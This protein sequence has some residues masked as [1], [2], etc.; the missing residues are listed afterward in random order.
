MPITFDT[1]ACRNFDNAIQNEWLAT[2]GLG[3]Y[4]SGTVAGA[5]SR[6]YHGYLVVAV[7]PPVQR[8]VVLSRV[9]DSVIVGGPGDDPSAKSPGEAST[10][11]AGGGVY[12]LSTDEFSDI[13]HPQGYK[14]LISFGLTHGPTW[15]FQVGD[16]VIEKS[17]TLVHGADAVIVRYTL[18]S[19]TG[20]APV[21]LLVQPMLAG[22]DFHATIN[23]HQR[24]WWTV[25]TNPDGTL[26]MSAP[27]CP[28]KLHISHNADRFTTNA[29]WWYNFTYRLERQ[30][31]Y[32]DREDLWTPGVLEFTLTPNKPVGF[33][34]ATRPM[35]WEK[36]AELIAQ[37]QRRYDHLAA[38]FDNTDPKDD[39]L[40]CLAQAADQ[41]VVR[42]GAPESAKSHGP[43][44]AGGGG[45]GGTGGASVIAGYPWFE[46]W[47][48]DTFISLPG[49]T[50]TRGLFDVARNILATFAD[51]LRRGLLPNRFPDKSF[52]PDYNTV[53]ASLWY[54]HAAYQYWRYTGDAAFLTKYLYP[55]LCE[56]MEAYRDGTD[57]GIR[58]TDD[59]LIRAGDGNH[60]P[61][62]MDAKIGDWV[63]TPRHG[64]PVEINALWY[65]NLRIMALVAHHAGDASRATTFA[66]LADKVA[67][68]F[69]PIYFNVTT[70][71]LN[72][73][74]SDDGQADA[75]IRPNQLLAVSLPF[76]PLSTEARIGV[77][78]ACQKLLLTP[79]GL[80]TLAP[81]SPQYHGRCQGDQRNR[82]MAYHQGTVWPWLI[83]PF[84][85][86][87]VKIRGD[88]QAASREAHAF[89]LPFNDHLKHFGLG[90]ISEIADGDA[91]FTPRGCPA[92]AWSVAEVLRAYYEDVLRRAPAWPHESNTALPPRPVLV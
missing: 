37:A 78:A 41:F 59:G 30:R 1:E 67:R 56:I 45:G 55:K 54:V 69:E 2:N 18:V 20:N 38:T 74:I 81:G 10:S 64:K 9:E 22:R 83:G 70:K 82:D 28:V 88:N 16:A 89:L 60:Q 51:H 57:F 49:L 33:I 15:R 40:A 92:Q 46:D 62:W 23:L 52:T 39:F 80:R 90:S 43:S 6:K 79:M 71:C 17:L 50:L 76:S 7:K 48:R 44:G 5:N 75:S 73:V 34:A 21:K 19:R 77:V 61:T 8:F 36:S 14:N 84:V 25:D 26:A 58:M 29:C 31:G 72:D 3:G 13:I 42:R 47:G 85:S 91:P 66:G 35:A 86:A 63:V 27:E 32:P 4:A 68:V 53:D 24:P 12:D 87:Y 11:A 65:S